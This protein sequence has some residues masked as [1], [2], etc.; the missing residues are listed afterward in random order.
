[1]QRKPRHPRARRIAG[2][3]VRWTLGLVTGL[4]LL[5]ALVVTLLLYSPGFLHFALNT[6]L[7]FYNG[8]IAGEIRIGR[9]EGRLIDRLVL[10]DIFIADRNGRGLVVAR[11]LSLT[12]NP[13][14]LFDGLIDVAELEVRSVQV[15]LIPGG[16]AD[17][18]IPGPPTPPRGTILPELPLDLAIAALRL[19]DVDIKIPDA[20]EPLVGGLRLASRDL[21][22]SGLS[23]HLKIDDAAAKLPGLALEALALELRWSEPRLE[24]RGLITTD[25]AIAELIDVELDA[26]KLDGMALIAVD[27]RRSALAE[28]IGG[29]VAERLRAAPGDPALR[30]DARTI[31]GT[32]DLGVHLEL[33]GLADLDLASTTRLRGSPNVQLRGRAM[34]DLGA[35]YGLQRPV[36]SATI[37]GDDWSRL[38]AELTLDCG[39]CGPLSGLHLQARARHDAVLSASAAQL[40]LGGVGLALRAGVEAGPRGL[41][42]GHWDLTVI[43]IAVPAGLARMFT[44]LR[45]MAGALTTRGSCTGSPLRCEGAL[46]LERFS[47]YGVAV[48]E[49]RTRLQAEPLAAIPTARAELSVRG[50]RLPGYQFA[51]A[52]LVA[53]VGPGEEDQPAGLE[54]KLAAELW[55]RARDRGDRIRLRA[56]ARPGPPLVIHLETL[57]LHMLGLRALLPRPARIELA[58]RRVAVDHLALRASGGQISVAGHADLDGPSDLRVVLERVQLAPLVALVPQLRGQ[59]GG[60]L[61]AR[62]TLVGPAGSPALQLELGG[63]QLRYRKGL[64]GDLDL[65][66]RVDAGRG[67]ATL[68]LRGP[69]AAQFAATGELPLTL[70]LSKGKFGVPNGPLH[71]ALDVKDLRLVQLRPW[72][73]TNTPVGRID[74]Q[75]AVDGPAARPTTTATVRGRGLLFGDHEGPTSFDLTLSQKSGEDAVARLDAQRLGGRLRVDVP[76]LPARLNLVTSGV[77]WHPERRHTATFV[78]RDLDL[79]RQLDAVG[80]GN[81]YYG[82][83]ELEGGLDGPMTAPAL[84]LTVTGDGL[85]VRD[86]QLGKLRADLK[87]DNQRATLDLALNGDVIQTSKV[88]AE[89]PLKIAVT[90]GEFIW[91]KGQPHVLDATLE[92]FDLTRL[93]D[94]GVTAKMDGIVDLSAKINGPLNAPEIG[95]NVGLRNF[96]WKNRPVGNVNADLSYRNGRAELALRSKVGRGT[97]D[98]RASVPLAVDLGRGKFTWDPS[99]QSEVELRV[100]GLDR[101]MLAPL[102]RVPEEAL[103]EL[104]LRAQAKGNLAEFGATLEAHGQLGHKLIGGAPVHI[105]ADIKPRSQALRFHIGPHK[106]AGEIEVK[107]DTRADVMALASG[108]ASAGDIPFVASMAAKELDTRF[109]QAFVPREYYDMNG[110]L[111]ARFDAKGTFADPEVRGAAKLRRG[112]ITVLQL[113]Q[114]IRKID[115]DVRAEGRRIVLERLTAESGKGQLSASATLDLPRG[116]M[117]LTGEVELR[118][119]P[120]VRP[121]LP[122]MQIDTQVA[123]QVVASAEQTDVKVQVRGTRVA[124]TGYTI[125]PPKRIPEN[126]RVTFRDQQ[127]LIPVATSGTAEVTAENEE[128]A[129]KPATPAPS[130]RFAVH[131]KLVDPVE[132]RGPAIEMAWKGAVTAIREGEHREVT[133]KLIARDGHFDLLGNSFKVESGEVTLPADEDTVDP[134]IHVVARTSAPTAEVTAT[135]KGRVSR[136]ELRF[137]SEPAMPQ[138]Q[139]LT[140]LLTGS[141]DA[142][143]ADEQRVLAQAAALLAT[144]ENPGLS[145]FLSSRLGIDRVGL[146]FGDDVNQPILSVGKRLSK[147]IYVETAYKFNAPRNRNRVEARVEYEFRPNWTLETF[148]GDAAVGGIDLFWHRVFGQPKRLP[149]NT[150]PTPRGTGTDETPRSRD[151]DDTPLGGGAGSAR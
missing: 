149:G 147:R 107:A 98:G 11:E 24:L 97:V 42:S 57:D 52:E 47:G 143:E 29:D 144:F 30:I 67:R 103:L 125:D 151:N 55:V 102:G 39:D 40:E 56:R 44:P 108:R 130:K 104:S 2:K 12:W 65:G 148:F 113:Q 101:T 133:G 18:A 80:V 131:I 63:Q 43:D 68:G 66:V 74:A 109:M 64:L 7:G 117:K 134:F 41:E 33:P 111:N 75:I 9:V 77:E 110:L 78:L 8:R 50:L 92:R 38:H 61:S 82:Q 112:S 106:W 100:D 26:A 51:G 119:F 1:M 62:A 73:G 23:A 71:L 36:F 19:E 116:G 114:R 96:V 141:A 28:R 115:L 87:L 70:D 99:G 10:G 6:G 79:Y 35:R 72:L 89:V 45:P 94:L 135:V 142:S 49:L 127:V 60:Q 76:R 13:W 53:E 146:S 91:L 122:Q 95:V 25:L 86:A 129:P 121:G 17:L 31:A 137:S 83:I 46:G 5:L 150:A 21:E 118:K 85:R 22:W 69:L 59:L 140:L 16:F 4:L 126:R 84:Q 48:S 32:L 81:N 136:P 93:K 145:N 14:A 123:A 88:H 90:R 15:T 27:G 54:G 20:S 124:V 37:A 34:A 138:S 139:I 58:G 105:T 128:R 120:L 132:I 3:L